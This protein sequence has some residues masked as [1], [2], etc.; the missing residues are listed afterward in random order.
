MIE[1]PYP[2]FV[3][4]EKTQYIFKSIGEKDVLKIVQI[5][6][7]DEKDIWNL[8]FG[9]LGDDGFV[10]DS[11]VTNNHDAQKVLRTVAKIAID[12]LE[13]YPDH[14]LE[15]RPVD[16]KRKR[17]Y[18]GIFQRYFTELAPMFKIIGIFGNKKETYTTLKIYDKFRITSKS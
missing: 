13:K 5:S 14:T 7:L 2:Y 15:I 1:Q 6:P 8:G 11:V 4:Q 3:L 18:N 16:T 12:F 9:D 10:D 17:L